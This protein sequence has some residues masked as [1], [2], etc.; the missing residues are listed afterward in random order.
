MIRILAALLALT[1]T[2]AAAEIATGEVGPV[3]A[4]LRAALHLADFYQK[5]LEVGGLPVLGS[6]KVSD[7]ALREAAWIVTRMLDG[8]ADILTALA[9]NNVR[10]TVMAAIEYTTD[11]PEHAHLTPRVYWDRRAPWK[12]SSAMSTRVSTTADDS[13]APSPRKTS[14]PTR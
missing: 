3:P 11:V 5:H 6:A 13:S 14:P 1:F 7:A 9:K 12:T 8:R 2:A 10:L 4:E